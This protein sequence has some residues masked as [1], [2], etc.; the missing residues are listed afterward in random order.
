MIVQSNE[1]PIIYWFN[2]SRYQWFIQS[3]EVPNVSFYQSR[4]QLFIV[5]IEVPNEYIKHSKYQALMIDPINR[6]TNHW[7]VRSIEVPIIYSFNESRYQ[8]FNQSRYQSFI[9]SIEVPIIFSIKLSILNNQGTNIFTWNIFYTS[10]NANLKIS[11]DVPKKIFI[12]RGT[13]V[14]RF[15]SIDVPKSFP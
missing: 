7:L 3:I 5:S 14:H 6:G 11:I 2:Q 9:Q 15:M 8:S 12:N 13:L 4:Y 1:V 10:K